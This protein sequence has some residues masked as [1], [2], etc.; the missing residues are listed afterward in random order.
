MFQ[1]HYRTAT[2]RTHNPRLY[3]SKERTPSE[4]RTSASGIKNTTVFLY[5]PV[6]CLK[7][8]DNKLKYSRTTHRESKVP[9]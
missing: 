1:L 3:P 4:A 2:G 8:S 7:V 6:T 5:L 9:A